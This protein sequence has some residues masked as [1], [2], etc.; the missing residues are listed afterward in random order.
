MIAS[1]LSV[2]KKSV[3][4]ASHRVFVSARGRASRGTRAGRRRTGPSGRPS[5]S[6]P[7]LASFTVLPVWPLATVV[8]LRV[9]VT[10]CL[11]R[12]AAGCAEAGDVLDVGDVV[13]GVVDLDRVADVR[14][15]RER[16]EQAGG[17]ADGRGDDGL[18]GIRALEDVD[19][20]DVAVALEGARAQRA[21][22]R[23]VEV[24][25]GAREE[26]RRADGQHEQCRPEGKELRGLRM[27]SIDPFVDL[28]VW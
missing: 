18:R 24:V 25:G 14:A 9:R 7:P 13:A 16:P 28:L 11:D 23:G 21:E 5:K 6:F 27:V 15:E 1:V 22:A 4:V 8:P 10:V 12:A 17:R 19:I 3:G 20:V 26:R 2:V